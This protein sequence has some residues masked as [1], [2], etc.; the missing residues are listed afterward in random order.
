[1]C[2]NVKSKCAQCRQ[3]ACQL[4][5][6]EWKICYFPQNCSGEVQSGIELHLWVL[7]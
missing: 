3:M 4:N 2:L 1:M 5:G 6:V 7:E